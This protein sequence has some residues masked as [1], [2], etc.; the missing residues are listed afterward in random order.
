MGNKIMIS[1]TKWVSNLANSFTFYGGGSSGGGSSKTTTGIDPM[2]KP[3]VTYGLNEAQNLYQSDTPDYYGGQTYVS[4][5]EQ[6]QTA[7]QAAQNRALGGNPLLPAAQQQQMDVIGG[8]YLQNNP[9]FNQAMQGAAQGATTSY[10]D[11]INQTRSGASQAG[12]YGSGAMG[13]LEGRQEQNLANALANQYGQ[14]A[15]QNYGAE[16]GRQ[17]AAA[18][19]AP[20]LAQADY[21]DIQQLMNVGQT[22]E[23]YQKT[24]LQS[25]IDR[26]NFEQNL[27]YSKL[28]TFLSSVY[29]A[30]QGQ[31]SQTTQSGGGKII[32][33]AM[34]EHYG[35]GSFRQKIWLAHS[36]SM[37]NAKTYEKGYHALFL[38]M[39]NFAYRTGDGITRRIVRAVLNHIA[40]HRTADLWKIKHGKR[41]ALGMIYRGIF[42]PIC[43]VVGK[44]KGGK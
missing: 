44:V 17:E 42:E 2:L 25:D 12:R 33:T 43:Y 6:T 21:G 10:L 35:F 3:Y 37:P 15:Y 1:L 7:L 30:P 18:G 36:A 22:M 11:A 26:F 27:P 32:C 14:L 5:T 20:Q 4:P 29:G 13:Q 31:V 8:N 39:V 16:R 24:A 40:R 23:D 9:Y 28:S 19:A 41:N 38:P 34:N